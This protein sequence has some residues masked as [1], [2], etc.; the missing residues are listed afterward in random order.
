MSILFAFIF[1]N[2]YNFLAKNSPI[3]ADVDVLVV[4]GWLPDY[5][6]EAAMKEFQVGNYKKIITIGSNL[7]RGSHL[8]N[9]KTFASLAGATLVTLGLDPEKLLIVSTSYV[10]ECRTQNAANGLK[11]HLANTDNSIQSINVFT[12]GPHARRTWLVFRKVFPPQTQ[13]GIIAAEPFGYDP[14]RWWQ[15]SEGV[16]TV[17]GEFIA[18]L[19]QKVSL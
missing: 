14:E 6:I 18:Y 4:E 7:P 19:Y 8:S 9:Y 10:P 3:I 1:F 12:L 11:D 5:A 17:V 2:L 16:R 13:V 15:T